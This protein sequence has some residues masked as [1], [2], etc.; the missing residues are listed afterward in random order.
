LMLVSSSVGNNSWFL[1]AIFRNFNV[2]LLYFIIYSIFLFLALST[3]SNFCKPL[4]LSRSNDK[5]YLL[6]ILLVRLRGLPPFPLF[7]AKMFVLLTLFLSFEPL[8][9][10]LLFIVSS[11]LILIGYVQVLSKFFLNELSC[12]TWHIV[13]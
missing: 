4:A 1:L 11:S 13:K 9:F 12:Q 6:S 3:L 8:H 10:M 2:F 7:F 5:Y